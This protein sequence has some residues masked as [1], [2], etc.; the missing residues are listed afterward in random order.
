MIYGIVSCELAREDVSTDLVSFV[1]LLQCD[2]IVERSHSHI[3]TVHDLRPR[4]ECVLSYGSLLDDFM[5]G[6]EESL[7]V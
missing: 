6:W 5:D 1:E 7:P 3:T 2:C 4:H